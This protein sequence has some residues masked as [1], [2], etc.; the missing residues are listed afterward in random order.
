MA[1][2]LDHL[3]SRSK[4]EWM[5][6]LQCDYT[7]LRGENIA[8][9]ANFRRTSII[10]TIGPRT[11]SV[12][13]INILRQAGL[14]VVR[15]N[16]SHG[17]YDYHQSVIDNARRAEQVQEGRPLAIA[18]DTKGPEIRT[19][20]TLD[21][22]DI[23][24]T[25]GTEL[26]IT[27]HDDYAEKSD[28]NH[29][30]VD[31]K[32]I[33]KVISKGKLIYVDDG[34]L[35]FQ[36]LEIIDD[37]SLRAKCLNNGVISSKKGVNLPGTDIDLPAL[38]EKDKEDLRFGVK[39]KVDM[40]FASFIRR[41]SDIR[42]IRAVLGEEGR[43]IQ[44]IA[45][46][47]NEQG[48]NNFDE[49]LDETDGVMVARG[50]LGIEIPAS[51]VFIAQKMMIAKCNIKGKPVI[52]A[53]QMLESMT[54]NPRPTRAEVSDVANAVLDGA[55]CVMLSGETAKGDY[56]KEAVSMMHETCLIA[57]VAIP[58][59]NV[60]DEL[61]NL[62]PRPMDTVESIAMAAVSASL[63]LNAGAILVLTTSGHS[64]RLLSKYR[65]ICPI[66]MVTRNGMAAR[67]SHLYRGVYPFIFPEKKPDFNQKNWQEDVDNRLK[68]G[69]A[70][71]IQ[72]Q[73]LSLGDSVV[74]VQGWRG[75]MGHTNTIRVVPADPRNLGLAEA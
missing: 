12:E 46:I 61:R 30:Y 7:P 55:D 38:S 56:P 6:K 53:T 42:D 70:K 45:K 64:A 60:F 31:Y 49:I 63:E 71:A 5:S 62:A 43:E 26:I 9:Y 4:L 16:F 25:E 59:V 23:K 3:T 37:S 18:L 24:I 27:S 41:A 69:I 21:G 2:S 72:H 58:Y 50:D 57:E 40:I 19:G 65:P 51:K 14:N 20:K 17:D 29:L 39:N 47:E 1:N 10:G 15:M 8:N 68:F 66:I 11:N 36:V 35:S 44:I 33:T 52:C 28:I 32:N 34:I 67:Y 75:G 54:Y 73:V 13:K 74:C 22:K 48:V